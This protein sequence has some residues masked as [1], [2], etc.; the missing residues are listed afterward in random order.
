M[1]EFNKQIRAWI[2]KACDD[3]GVPELKHKIDF[4][5][6]GKFTRRLGDARYRQKTK[7]GLIRLSTP[8]WPRATEAEQRDTVIHEA[9]HVVVGYKYG[10][11]QSHGKE[12]KQAMWNCGL[13]AERTHC[14]DRTG[15]AR[16]QV[17]WMVS[18][19][20]KAKKCSVN[21]KDFNGVLKAG[22]L[23]HCTACGIKVDFHSVEEQD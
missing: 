13:E 15:I 9:C 22:K 23:L 21:Q 18:E 11:V 12:W 1:N 6:N 5:F 14:L 19:C 7:R 3:N 20:P 8:L 10:N 17:R 4:E 2:D 16:K